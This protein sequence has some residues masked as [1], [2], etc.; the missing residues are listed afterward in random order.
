[1]AQMLDFQR[2]STYVGG[3]VDRKVRA[4]SMSITGSTNYLKT[5]VTQSQGYAT[6]SLTHAGE[7]QQHAEDADTAAATS[8]IV[9][10]NFTSSY[11]GIAETD[12]LVSSLGRPVNL[13]AIY[14]RS[15]DG[16]LRWANA[17]SGGGVPTWSDAAVTAD[18]SQLGS[19]GAGVFLA[20][21]QTTPSQT[22]KGPITFQNTLSVPRVTTWTSQQP[23]TAID[24]N[25]R[26]TTVTNA[27][28]AE[29]TRATTAEGTLNTSKVAKVGD[30]MSGALTIIAR[31]AAASVILTNNTTTGHIYRWT[32]NNNGSLTL[33]DDT[34]GTDRVVINGTGVFSVFGSLSSSVSMAAPFVQTNR[35]DGGDPGYLFQ[36]NAITRWSITRSVSSN[37]LYITRYNS[38]GVFIDTPLS[39]SEADGSVNL[40]KTS[41]GGTLDTAGNVS[42]S[43][44]GPQFTLN[45]SAGNNTAC[46]NFKTLGVLR[47]QMGRISDGAFYIN[48]HA[49]NG[50]W[51]STD[52]HIDDDTGLVTVNTLKVTANSTGKNIQLGDDAYIGDSDINS[53]MTVRGGPTGNFNSGFI[54]FGNA[55]T[56]LGC[57]ASDA[58]LRYNNNA[59]YHE[60]NLTSATDH[61]R[62]GP[63][64]IQWGKNRVSTNQV[65]VTFT[66]NYTYPF[67]GPATS[68]QMT[69]YDPNSVT[70]NQK[71]YV[72]H[73][74]GDANGFTYQVQ[75]DDSGNSGNYVYGFDWVAYGPA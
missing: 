24:V 29:T 34:V 25:D 19:A 58:T 43:A 68:V 46:I 35:T 59:I 13:G 67:S 47:W 69:R 55:G 15:T 9:W 39:V 38:S 61:I 37:K 70:Y 31:D 72:K 7:A 10:N 8:L 18:L 16:R 6:E 44:V 45:N 26:I 63:L 1:M 53:T 51:I 54:S 33:R 56:K 65:G 52:F 60:G 12:P 62:I 74:D 57:N 14:I 21:E 40:N 27:L 23:A 17:I 4:I 11:I 49:T 66:Q 36:N 41:I 71:H 75:D 5:L 20:L 2:L 42:V 32:S 64:L 50:A 48:R 28:T 22:V 30:T 3:I 73:S